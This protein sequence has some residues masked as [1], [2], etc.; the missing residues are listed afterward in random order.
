[1]RSLGLTEIKDGNI[2]IATDTNC[3]F[4]A[5]Q[6]I[7]AKQPF[8]RFQLPNCMTVL[9]IVTSSAD[10]TSCNRSKPTA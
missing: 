10:M 5:R 2:F 9:A 6:A 1:M 3:T 4:L 7:L 8:D